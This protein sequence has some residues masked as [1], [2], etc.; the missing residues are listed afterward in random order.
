MC[1]GFLL[2]LGHCLQPVRCPAHLLP[3]WKRAN[4][5]AA[6]S[7]TVSDVTV[8]GPLAL[9]GNMPC[10]R[11][12]CQSEWSLQISTESKY[13]WGSWA[14]PRR[15]PLW[16]HCS[17]PTPQHAAAHAA[18]N[19]RHRQVTHTCPGDA[20]SCLPHLE[21]YVPFCG[22]C[23]ASPPTASASWALPYLMKSL[24][25]IQKTPSLLPWGIRS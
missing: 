9:L 11:T 21:P 16:V 10:T 20:R 15:R 12:S 23:L 22:P 4:S 24:Y 8:T 17:A 25:S 3:S 2:G 18:G 7:N 6:R 1:L 19:S 13:L 14:Q 5:R